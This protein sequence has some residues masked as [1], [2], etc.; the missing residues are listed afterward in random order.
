[1]DIKE[2]IFEAIYQGTNL[3]FEY[4]SSSGEKI[5]IS[6]HNSNVI[7]GG[8]ANTPVFTLVNTNQTY[9]EDQFVLR[10]GDAMFGDLSTSTTF[11]GGFDIQERPDL[12]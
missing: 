10:K 7:S 6:Y 4:D 8:N 1:M 9:T 2:Q 3:D 12:V 5:N 11:D